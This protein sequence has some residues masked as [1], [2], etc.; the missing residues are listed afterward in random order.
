MGP[1]PSGPTGPP[2]SDSGTDDAYP[3]S[4]IETD[5]DDQARAI[6]RRYLA[7]LPDA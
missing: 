5:D 7:P 1:D 6:A 3:A 2:R 4:C